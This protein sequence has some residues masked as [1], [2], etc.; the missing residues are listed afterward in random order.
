MIYPGQGPV[1]YLE[2][3]E[4]LRAQITSG[5]LPPGRRLPSETMLAQT[6]GVAPKTARAA[7]MM[8]RNEGLAT[9]VRGYGV[10]VREHPEPELV[11]VDAD[12]TVSARMP[13]PAERD[14]YDMPEGVPLILVIHADGLQDLYPADRYRV[15]FRTSP[16]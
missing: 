15:A 10:V 3:A 6:Y 8:L 9:A 5:E 14:T 12:D 2:L 7:L 16:I 13:S 1:G 4:I 11:T